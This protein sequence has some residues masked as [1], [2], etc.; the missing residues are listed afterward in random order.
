MPRQPTARA[1]HACC[2]DSFVFVNNETCTF[3]PTH[4]QPPFPSSSLIK[5]MNCADAWLANVRAAGGDLEPPPNPAI[6]AEYLQ[7]PRRQ[8]VPAAHLVPPPSFIHSSLAPPKRRRAALSEIES[9]NQKR[10]RALHVL[11][12]EMSQS[13]RSP[14]RKSSRQAGVRTTKTEALAEH[15]LLA[16]QHVVDPNAT[17]RQT[18]R[19][20]AAPPSLPAPNLH[21]RP[22]PV[23]T[24]SASE[25]QVDE[26]AENVEAQSAYE[27]TTSKRSRSPTRRMVDLQIA[28]KPVV[29]KSATFSTDV[30]QDVRVLYKTVQA[31]ARRSKGVIPLGIEAEIE[32]DSHGDLEDLE[33]YVAKTSHDK[34]HEQLKDEFKAMREIRNETLVCKTKHLH[35][36]GWNELVHGPMLKQAALG[37]A[38]F[39]YYNITTARVVR[40]LVPGN[41][42][43]ELL[44]GKMIDFAV[45]L[46]PPLIPT[47]HV[48][49]RLAASPPKL[50]R[51]INPP[52][53]SPLC[54]EPVVLSIETKSPDGGGENGEVQLSLWAMAYFNRLRQLMQD[55]VTMALPLLLVTDARWKLYFASDLGDEIHLIDA[56][57]IGTTADIIGC[58]TIL[59]ALRVILRWIEETFAPWFLN[60]L[61]PE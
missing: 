61:K 58:Y 20:R 30:P 50:Q 34:T 13:S 36:P 1:M 22:A 16:T 55:P 18:L 8:P 48:I 46:G 5:A 51:T 49:N 19:K 17:P 9:A 56:V 42:Y 29:S 24:P 27:S 21:T 41:E 28:R 15:D 53:Y 14:T 32:K 45:T 23:L 38:G 26:D 3:L 60:G 43:G 7:T 54:Y 11:G 10:Q 37:R 33:D 40:G 35:E 44:K 6:P 4:R 57:D 59:E 47:A 39:S 12:R 52:D 2:N 25:E 31:L